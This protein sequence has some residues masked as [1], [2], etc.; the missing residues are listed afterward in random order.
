MAV[1]APLPLIWSDLALKSCTAISCNAPSPF[2]KLICT[3][4]FSGTFRSGLTWPLILPFSPTNTNLPSCTSVRRVKVTSG[5]M[6][7]SLLVSA[8]AAELKATKPKHHTF[9]IALYCLVRMVT[10][11]LYRIIETALPSAKPP[12]HST[13]SQHASDRLRTT[14]DTA[15]VT[16]PRCPW[17]MNQRS[18]VTL[19]KHQ[20]R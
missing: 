14:C 9:K 7:T 18:I 6:V 3:T 4:D 8:T 5:R 11:P 17:P 10:S 2:T 19:V 20:P 1:A 15:T 13:P 16:P 12:F